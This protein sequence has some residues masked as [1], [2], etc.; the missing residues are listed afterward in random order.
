MHFEDIKKYADVI[1]KRLDD[2]YCTLESVLHDNA[3]V[4][5]EAEK[6]GLEYHLIDD[7]YNTDIDLSIN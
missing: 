4:L 1:E 6:H 3:Y 7:E 2:S 5:K